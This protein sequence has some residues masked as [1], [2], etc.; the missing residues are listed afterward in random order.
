MFDHVGL[1]VTDVPAA[2]RLYKAMLEPLGFVCSSED[3]TSAG[4]GPKG[5]TALWL[6]P[7]GTA[8]AGAHVAVRAKD[9]KAV[10][11]FHRAALAAG[12]KDNG[13]PGLRADYGP[14]YYAAF[15]TDADGNNLEAVTFA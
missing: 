14:K 6:S 8:R 3:A 2:T 10:D 7:L 12:G 9:R 15:I 1:R 5:E 13:P 4:F 11:A